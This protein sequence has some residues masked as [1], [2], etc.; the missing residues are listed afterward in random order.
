MWKKHVEILYTVSF[1]RLSL[2]CVFTSGLLF[3]Q[4]LLF[5][6][7]T[8]L[9]I[10]AVL[11]GIN[12]KQSWCILRYHPAVQDHPFLTRNPYESRWMEQSLIKLLQCLEAMSPLQSEWMESK[13]TELQIPE[14]YMDGSLECIFLWSP[15]VYPSPKSEVRERKKGRWNDNWLLCELFEVILRL[16]DTPPTNHPSKKSLREGVKVKP[17][18]HLFS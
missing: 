14:I 10:A 3:Q 16:W 7:Q 4:R 17:N 11:R 13:F 2:E 6:L 15:W 5:P 9:T 1:N 12:F 8:T 18:F